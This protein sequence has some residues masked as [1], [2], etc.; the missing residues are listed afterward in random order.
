[1]CC[2]INKLFYNKGLTCK[3]L[4]ILWYEFCSCLLKIS[5]GHVNILTCQF[6]LLNP[7]Y[8]LVY[9]INIYLLTS[10][11]HAIVTLSQTN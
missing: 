3:N 1:M 5:F 4:I 8:Y 7:C 6:M 9:L 2:V 11:V 10:Q